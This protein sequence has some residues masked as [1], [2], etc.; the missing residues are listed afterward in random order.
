MVP[1]YNAAMAEG[2]PTRLRAQRGGRWTRAVAMALLLL[3]G[4]A[5]VN[6]AFAWW[7]NCSGGIGQGMR[8]TYYDH[9][10]EVVVTAGRLDSIGYT[11]FR[12]S[13]TR[14]EHWPVPHSRLIFENER[15]VATLE[16]TVPR[17]IRAQGGR[18]LRN[19]YRTAGLPFRSI[20]AS[21][22]R[23]S[24]DVTEIV[25]FYELAVGRTMLRPSVQMPLTPIW[26]GFI[27][28]TLFYAVVLWLLFIAPFEARRMFRR[29]R[30]LCE[31]CAYP[32]GASPVCTECGAAVR[33]LR[34]ESG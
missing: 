11:R 10:R 26:P 29:R 30:A 5:I 12:Y 16:E 9:G 14:V 22:L 17:R 7:L 25:R 1:L 21:D 15:E 32:I 28:N 6:I 19:N 24:L 8:L 4:G 18:P 31:K 20:D 34:P 33:A 13:E 2:G 23:V 3:A 27:V